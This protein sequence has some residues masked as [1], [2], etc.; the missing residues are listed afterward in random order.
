[1]TYF[2]KLKLLNGINLNLHCAFESF[3][4][5]REGF[6]KSIYALRQALRQNFT[7][8]KAYQKFGADRKMA[9]CPTF[10]LYEIYPRINSEKNIR[11]YR[12]HG[13]YA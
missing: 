1:M 4:K 2:G 6:H 9:L 12:V 3:A 7:P 10:S 8:E 13:W 11:L 5:T